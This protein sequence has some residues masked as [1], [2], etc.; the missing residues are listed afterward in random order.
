MVHG[1]LKGVRT[2]HRHYSSVI[3]QGLQQNILITGETPPRARLADFGLSTLIPNAQ[4]A[5]TTVTSGG[6][7]MF[8]APEL[9]CP[10]T[11]NRTSSRPTQPADIYAFGM[12]IYEVLAGSQPFLQEGWRGFEIVYRVVSGV[13]PMK[14]VD[15]E[16]IGF[17]DG[18]WELVQECWSGESTTRPTIDQVLAHLTR[19]AANSKAV[20]RTPDQPRKN[21]IDTTGPGS[22]SKFF[23]ASF[24]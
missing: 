6:T 1:D 19:V 23:E 18:I 20:G 12:V 17:V 15:A 8:M 13:R 11:F 16:Q 14:P 7:P 4:E 10:A 2:S 3:S 24:L 22:S 21:T 9:L 5:G